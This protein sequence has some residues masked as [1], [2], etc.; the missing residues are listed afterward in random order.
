[1]NSRGSPISKPIDYLDKI[2]LAYNQNTIAIEFSAMDYTAPEK[3]Q[4]K[5][6]LVGFDDDWVS[7][8]TRHEAIYTNLFPAEYKFIVKAANSEGVW[9]ELGRT[10]T[11]VVT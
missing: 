9:N 6:K 8:D 11:I 3:N 2:V 1:V 7:S 4:Y 10:I 5:Y